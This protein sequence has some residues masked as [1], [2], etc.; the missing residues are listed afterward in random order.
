MTLIIVNIIIRTGFING[1]WEGH[2]FTGCG[3]TPFQAG[4]GK[5]TS[6]LVPLSP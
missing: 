4:F 3:K 6:F 2:G 1:F 5:G